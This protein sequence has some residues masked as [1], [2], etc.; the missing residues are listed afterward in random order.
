M[1]AARRRT[2]TPA[3]AVFVGLVLLAMGL[4]SA[5]ERGSDS[6]KDSAAAVGP[7]DQSRQSPSEPAAGG[8]QGDDGGDPESGEDAGGDHAHDH[9]GEGHEEM[10]LAD[11]MVELSRRYSA[12]WFAGQT[13][14]A[15]MIE[16]QIHEI[17]ELYQE[18][19]AASPTENGVDVASRLKADIVAPL[20][21]LASAA[22]ESDLSAFEGRY[23]AIMTN[24]ESCHADT[25][26]DF[27]NVKQPE[28]NPYPNLDMVPRD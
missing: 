28:Y 7:A 18:V 4:V 23:D 8:E 20:E 5:C 2:P 27:I 12:I 26:H 3:A 17:E 13:G 6:G 19:E 11:V 1:T 25:G 15:P 21:G 14:N 24:C 16:Y 10:H 9:G 22:E